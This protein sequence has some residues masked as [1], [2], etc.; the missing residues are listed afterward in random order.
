VEYSREGANRFVPRHKFVISTEGEAE[1]EKPAVENKRL[2][3]THI[4]LLIF[5]SNWLASWKKNSY[6]N[7]DLA[8]REAHRPPLNVPRFALDIPLMK[9]S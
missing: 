8:I 1:V 4:G 5:F 2:G 3:S 9:T 6:R 7:T